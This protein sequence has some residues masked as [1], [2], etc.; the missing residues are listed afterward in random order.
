MNGGSAD[1]GAVEARQLSVGYGD[2]A[3]LDSLCFRFPFG[4][5]SVML[6]PGGSGK[7]T[8]LH[9]LGGRLPSRPEPWVR[10]R[11]ERPSAAPGWLAQKLAPGRSSLRG[12]LARSADAGPGGGSAGVGRSDA[13]RLARLWRCAPA[14]AVA[15]T[16]SLD[17]PVSALPYSLARLAEITAVTASTAGGD[18]WLLLDEPDAELSP[19]HRAWV[20]LRLREL[21]GTTTLV[22]ATHHLGLARALADHVV[23]LIDGRVVETGDAETFFE[24]PVHPRAR[25]FVRMGS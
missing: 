1:D 10:G 12:L 16:A 21:R 23:L 9:A 2:H 24:H 4:R 8:L 13:E 15:L 3:V 19:E 14:A 6:G 5:T 18:G 7:T 11:L 17:E 25:R 20:E 22:V